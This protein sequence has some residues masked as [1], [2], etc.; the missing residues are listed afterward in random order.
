MK[1]IFLSMMLL[2]SSGLLLAA[3][4]KGP[5]DTAP[6][7]TY[8]KPSLQ[9]GAQLFVNNCMGCHSANYM[10]Y[11]RMG[12]DLGLSDA[13]VIHN[14]IFTEAK[15]GDPMSIAMHPNDAKNWFG[16]APPD[17]TLAARVYGADWLYTFLR[18][19][20]MDD[21]KPW[22]VNNLVF[23]D[24]AMPHVLLR[25]QG[26]Q[27][28]IIKTQTMEFEGETTS[29]KVIEGVELLKPGSMTVEQYNRAVADLVNFLVY[30]GEPH[31]HE[32][33]RLGVWVLL[34]LTVFLVFAYL[35]KREYWKDTK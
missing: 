30:I 25:L 3:P 13:E 2:V 8:D 16:V 9:R 12:K 5:L 22:G 31:R 32:R 4:A 28:P 19:F 35:L 20:Y 1:K 7:D 15:I 33:L 26:E 14:L 6:I 17:L 23:P 21:S 11:Q 24:T 34:F 27:G 10:R 29:V 18:T